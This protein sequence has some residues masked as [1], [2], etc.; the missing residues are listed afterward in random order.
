MTIADRLRETAEYKK[1]IDKKNEGMKKTLNYIVERFSEHPS[2]AQIY[3]FGKLGRFC[4]GEFG[5]ASMD[6]VSSYLRDNG[7][8]VERNCTGYGVYYLRITL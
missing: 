7:F 4:N 1:F 8:N 6:E 5:G 3:Y 2:W